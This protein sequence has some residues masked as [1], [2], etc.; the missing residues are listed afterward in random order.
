VRTADPEVL[1]QLRAG[2]GRA[3]R[4]AESARAGHVTS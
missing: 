1:A 2:C 3:L 4:A